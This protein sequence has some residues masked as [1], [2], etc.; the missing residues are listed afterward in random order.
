MASN[1]MR[2]LLAKCP[3]AYESHFCENS[4]SLALGYLAA[5]LRDKGFDVD[6]LDAALLGLSQERTISKILNREYSLMGFTIADPTYV[7]STTDAIKILRHN[8]VKSH[9][10]MGGH[11]PTF[12]HREVLQMCP[13]LDSISMYEGEKTIVELAKALEENQDWRVVRSLAYRDGNGARCNPL[14]PLI[15]DLDTLPFSARDTVPF[16]L[17][18]KKEEGVV[19]MAGGRG[20]PMNCGFCS[21][22]AFYDA[23]RGSWWRVRSNKNIVDEMEYLVSTYGVKEILMVDD[24][25][26]GPG[27]KNKHRILDLVEEIKRRH[28][29][30][31]LSVAERVDNIEEALFRTLRESG[32]RNILLGIESGSQQL[33]D[34][35]N[36]G[37]TIEQIE[38][39]IETLHN[40]GIDI[41]VSFINFTPLTTLEQLKENIKF[42]VNLDVNILQGLLNRFQ[43]YG[44]TPL[45][46]QLLST[47]FVRGKFPNFSCASV[48]KRVD[49][50]Y[51]IAKKSLGTFLAIANEIN[52]TGRALRI[53]TFETE[54]RGAPEEIVVLKKDKAR[55]QR[56]VAKIVEEAANLLY[57]IIDFVASEDLNNV[58]VISKY[59]EKMIDTSL[60]T[61]ESWLGLIQFF[62]SSSAAFDIPEESYYPLNVD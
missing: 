10:T 23:P 54:Y 9:I 21:I 57:D 37:I 49:L 43:Y 60:S 24:V 47:G 28:L 16:I 44:G 26:I 55:H 7:E 4:E 15:A 3:R 8:G 52:K 35:F 12:H 1:E 36:K 61:Y 38:R 20:C 25:F 51:E 40:L 50:V 27:D 32:V 59:T 42:F 22:R 13:G 53:K 5:S 58:T 33:L 18:H 14:R 48:D 2:I 11:S 6:I 56:I 45:G 34:Y 46:E 19:S 39:A 30:V 62:E 31:M 29:T 41:T 17:E